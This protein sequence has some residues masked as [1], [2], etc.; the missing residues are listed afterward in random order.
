MALIKCPECGKSISMYAVQCPE[1]GL[2]K[3]YF[4]KIGKET[5]ESIISSPKEEKTKTDAKKKRTRHKLPNGFGYIKK[6]SGNRT[7]PYAAYPPSKEMNHKGTPLYKN[8]IG[9]YKTYN[10]AYKAV[11][12]WH[13]NTMKEKNKEYTFAEVYEMCQSEIYTNK[14]SE[15]TKATYKSAYKKCQKLYNMKI[16]DIVANDMQSI[17]DENNGGYSSTLQMLVLLG[18]IF[19]YADKND[20]V[21]KDYSKFLVNNKENDNE[22]GIPFTQ[23]DLK[24]LWKNRKIYEI[25]ILLILCYTGL[26]INELR[27]TNIYLEERY[28]KGGL[29]T[30]L[31]KK[32]IVP[33]IE[34][35][36][37]LFD[38]IQTFRKETAGTYRA[39][40]KPVL[41]EIGLLYVDDTVHTPHDARH[42]FSTIADKF[43]VEEISK[44]LIMGHVPGGDVEKK[45]YTHRSLDELRTEMNKIKIIK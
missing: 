28:M 45:V 7:N 30:P 42:T 41:E 10:E 11:T 38:E 4:N 20:M 3:E 44:Y 21:K 14:L 26:R 25:K 23:K 17:L 22:S 12:E 8:P 29:K 9:Y 24:I 39:K 15:S 34:D 31:G 43:G 16:K 32:R 5:V 35:I 37:P 18:K 36:V 19:H 6:L 27:I 2:P 13:N 1:C 40:L 33:I